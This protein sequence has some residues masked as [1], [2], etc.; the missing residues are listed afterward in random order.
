[1]RKRVLL[2]TLA[3][4]LTVPLLFG[5]GGEKA[6]GGRASVT[7]QKNTVSNVLE[8]G[9]S[10]AEAAAQPTQAATAAP[11]PTAAAPAVKMDVDLAAMSSTM[12]Y[13]EVYSM[14]THPQDYVGKTMRMH[15][16]FA[17]SEGNLY[18]FC[19]IQD[20]TACCGQGIEF[21]LK[22]DPPYPLGYPQ[23]GEEFT[24]TGVFEDYQEGPNTYYHLRDAVLG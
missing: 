10:A 13:S 20:A 8:A 16:I 5:C 19:V 14:M 12:V 11:A 4:L 3:L 6:D 18:Y 1:M 7:A 21:I 15:G 9:V 23:V 24:V 22:G 17:C 2:W